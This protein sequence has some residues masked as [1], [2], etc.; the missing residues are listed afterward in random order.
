MEN[1]CIFCGREIGRW[2]DEELLCGYKLQTV[3]GDCW[4][5][6]KKAPPIQRARL[7]LESGRAKDPEGIRRFLEKEEAQEARNAQ[8][9]EWQREALTCCGQRMQEMEQYAFRYR[10]W[11]SLIEGYAPTMTAF[12]CERCGQVKFFDTRF[13]SEE[14]PEIQI[15]DAP[16]ESPK[17]TRSRSGEKPPWEK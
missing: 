3:C 10:N 6:Y 5:R 15:P 4:E 1:I 13:L 16:P 9:R 7:A 17:P 8:R 14:Q 11:D 12:R 2:K